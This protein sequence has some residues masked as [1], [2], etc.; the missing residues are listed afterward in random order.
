MAASK[1]AY[2]EATDNGEKAIEIIGR[3]RRE[4]KGIEGQF[5]S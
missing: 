5:L 3:S 1:M 2:L 4:G